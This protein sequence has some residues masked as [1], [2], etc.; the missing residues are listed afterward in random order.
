MHGA[1]LICPDIIIIICLDLRLL[2]IANCINISSTQEF[3]MFKIFMC[4]CA[5]FIRLMDQHMSSYSHRNVILGLM[6]L[7]QHSCHVRQKTSRNVL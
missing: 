4:L 2:H 5:V 7:P 6:Y 1:W 3:L